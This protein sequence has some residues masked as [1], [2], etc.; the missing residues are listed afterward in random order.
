MRFSPQKETYDSYMQSGSS[1]RT[2]TNRVLYH[3]S[4][5]ETIQS[6]QG[7]ISNSS[8][9]T[10][11]VAIDKDI[12]D[13]SEQ[14]P[15]P[16][17]SHHSLDLSGGRDPSISDH[18]SFHSHQKQT[19]GFRNQSLSTVC[20]T[21]EPESN[22]ATATSTPEEKFRPLGLS[23]P[24]LKDGAESSLPS[25]PRPSRAIALTVITDLSP[26]PSPIYT[27]TPSPPSDDGNSLPL[28]TVK[29]STPDT[30]F[31]RPASFLSRPTDRI[32]T[33]SRSRSST[34]TTKGKKGMLG[35]MTDFLNSS[36]RPE[37][38]TPHDLVH[39]THVRFNSSTGKFT[40]L[41]TEW[42]QLLQDSGISE[43]DQEKNPLAV[44][45]V[46]KFY[47]EGGGDIWDRT[48]NSPAPGSPQSPPIS[49]GAH[50][51]SPGVSKT[52]HDSFVPT[53]SAV[54][55]GPLQP[56]SDGS[57]Q[58]A[59]ST[60]KNS[61]SSDD[62]QSASPSH[63][64]ASYRSASSPPLSAHPNL[65]RSNS[66]QSVPK[67]PHSDTLIRANTTKDRHYL[68]PPASVEAPIQ[69][70]SNSWIA[71]LASKSQAT[72]V[73]NGPV[74]RQ[75]SQPPTPPQQPNTTVTGLAK[76]GGATPRRREKMKKDKANDA[77]IVKHLQQI[78][79]DADPTRLYRNLVKIGQG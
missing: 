69:E 16:P 46:V 20:A 78:F 5:K 7:S 72:V 71:D 38:T 26:I 27:G 50:A 11:T 76:T 15:Y 39:V 51:V 3:E 41:P 48:A 70:S 67:S 25:T 47:Q 74:E 73:A 43:S 23:L 54:L 68:A 40:G 2:S 24:S 28:A 32:C 14:G 13:L 6:H 66:Q 65:N 49:G 79:M 42:Q 53:V 31:I 30:P 9:H 52:V 58:L 61:H 62:P 37:I 57:N 21:R 1:S 75:V 56:L 63:L 34:V 60:P 45:E 36:K 19:F 33:T 10:A 55:C 4:S 22:R 18:K 35:F 64:P 8:F 29:I 17:V 59:L 12:L 44:M 77:D